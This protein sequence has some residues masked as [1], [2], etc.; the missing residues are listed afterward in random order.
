MAADD[1]I[2]RG[3]FKQ[4]AFEQLQA[5][6]EGQLSLTMDKKTGKVEATAVE[7]VELDEAASTLLAATTDDK[8]NVNIFTTDSFET[9]ADA[10]FGGGALKR[11]RVNDNG[12]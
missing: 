8:I 11:S 12:T 2:L 3:N 1:V 5:S 6:V 4:E 9:A 7:G 10:D